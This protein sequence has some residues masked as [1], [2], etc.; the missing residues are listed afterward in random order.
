[1]TQKDGVKK[2]K[3]LFIKIH[4]ISITWSLITAVIAGLL[5]ALGTYLILIHFLA[6][7]TY[8]LNLDNLTFKEISETISRP[9]QANGEIFRTMRESRKARKGL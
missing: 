7:S 6:A 2:F 4:A 3:A 1:M 5:P 9:P 8:L